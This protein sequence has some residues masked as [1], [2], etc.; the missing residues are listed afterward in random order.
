M[1]I[2]LSKSFNYIINL[3]LKNLNSLN[4]QT[5]HLIP[6]EWKFILMSDGSFTQNLNS[7]TKQ[8]II[9][10]P[11][12]IKHQYINKQINIREVYLQDDSKT[13]LAFARSKWILQINN[14]TYN[15]VD[16][17]EPIGKSLIKDQADIYKDIHEIYYG[18]S[19]YLE[20]IFN[21]V[22]PI[23]GRKYTIY[24][25]YKPITT[26]QEFFSPYIISFF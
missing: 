16:N 9:T 24:Y 8:E 1:N 14:Q 19:I 13:N 12:Y 22:E 6:P 20:H 26:I 2:N 25:E 21:T 15:K 11:T 5:Y 18:Y 23:W 4:E 17:K 3:P 10:C 7:L